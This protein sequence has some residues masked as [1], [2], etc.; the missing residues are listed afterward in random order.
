[1]SIK[2]EAGLILILLSC[3]LIE[4][5]KPCHANLTVGPTLVRD[6]KANGTSAPLYETKYSEYNMLQF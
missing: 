2:E 5:F 3:L 4:I 1:M 6:G